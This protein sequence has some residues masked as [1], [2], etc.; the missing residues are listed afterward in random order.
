[1]MYNLEVVEMVGTYA[2]GF[3]MTISLIVIFQLYE[4]I[5]YKIFFVQTYN[6]ILQWFS[7]VKPAMLNP[8]T[9]FYC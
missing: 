9:S 6:L 8:R 2:G 4:N 5:S 3:N 7:T 1:M